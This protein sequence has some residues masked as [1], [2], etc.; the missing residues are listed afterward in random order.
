MALSCRL[1]TGKFAA[2]PA[3]V[4][5]EKPQKLQILAPSRRRP[6]TLGPRRRPDFMA[7]FPQEENWR[8]Q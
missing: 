7:V 4:G 6:I 5:W 3:A 8:L 1:A 2:L